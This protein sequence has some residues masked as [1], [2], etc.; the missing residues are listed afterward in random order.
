MIKANSIGNLNKERPGIGKDGLV[1]VCK[2]GS[3]KLK[4]FNKEGEK[5]GLYTTSA[6][7]PVDVKFDNRTNCYMSD[8]NGGRILKCDINRDL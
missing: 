4:I 1:Y 6:E 7:Q 8:V 2:R 3:Y 5:I